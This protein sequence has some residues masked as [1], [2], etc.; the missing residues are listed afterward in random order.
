[1]KN[2]NKIV[3]DSCGNFTQ[4]TIDKKGYNVWDNNGNS[5]Y[6]PY[7]K[8]NSPTFVSDAQGARWVYPEDI[9]V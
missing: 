8:D 5:M 7:E 6:I 3:I 4:E 1:M 2:T 9:K